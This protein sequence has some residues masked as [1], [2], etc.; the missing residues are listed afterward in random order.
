M[1]ESIKALGG[2]RPAAKALGIPHTTVASWKKKGKIP[3]WRWPQ[4]EEALRTQEDFQDQN[5]GR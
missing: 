4:I 2:I 1:I 5:A 3:S